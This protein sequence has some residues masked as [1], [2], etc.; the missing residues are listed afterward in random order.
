MSRLYMEGSPKLQCPTLKTDLL[1]TSN[2]VTLTSAIKIT[3]L[4]SKILG[5]TSDLL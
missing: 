5:I 1:G 2:F 3:L 4:F